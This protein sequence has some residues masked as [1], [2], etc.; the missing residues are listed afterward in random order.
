MFLSGLDDILV[1]IVLLLNVLLSWIC[2]QAIRSARHCAELQVLKENEAAPQKA[3]TKVWASAY[4]Q[5]IRES[6]NWWLIPLSIPALLTTGIYFAQI[7]ANQ[8]DAA[9]LEIHELAGQQRVRQML[10]EEKLAPPPSLPP[11]LFTSTGNTDLPSAN[12]DW[13]KLDFDFAQRVLQLFSRME[14][15]GY[16]LALLEGYRSAERQDIL[17]SRGNHITRVSGNQSKHQFG[18]AV[19]VAPLHDGRLIIQNQDEW[20]N[21]AYRT[22]GQEAELLG[23]TWGGRWSFRDYGHVE[24]SGSLATLIKTRTARNSTHH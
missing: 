3:L 18:L 20:A 12:R 14:K 15:R 11:M 16:P 10:A 23:M 24:M 2:L 7:N 1:V 9:Q 17:A 19:D 22:L 13:G 4:T 8:H 6:W 5:Y 21:E